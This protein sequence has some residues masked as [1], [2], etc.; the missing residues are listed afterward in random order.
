M[1]V[2]AIAGL[3]LAIVFLALPQVQRNS[4][5][6]QRQSTLNRI[7]AELD[8]YAGNNRGTYPINGSGLSL[9]GNY[10]RCNTITVSNG[11]NDWLTRYITGKVKIK[12]PSSSQDEV[13][14]VGWDNGTSV[15]TLPASINVFGNMFV[16][17]GDS[18][19]GDQISHPAGG[20]AGNAKSNKFALMIVLER[21][22]THACITNN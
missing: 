18:C 3:I 21:S 1:I 2:L 17:V 9:L 6:N 19:S 5:D 20:T 7:K 11:C 10:R 22:K 8:T 13:I 12:D 14:W 16:A 4:R 15:P